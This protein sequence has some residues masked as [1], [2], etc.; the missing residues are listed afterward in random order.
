MSCNRLEYIDALRG[1][2]MLMVVIGHIELFSFGEGIFL[3]TPIYKYIQ[4]PLFFFISG[5]IAAF[6]TPGTRI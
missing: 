5:Y 1:L 2:T 6:K 4:M 3:C